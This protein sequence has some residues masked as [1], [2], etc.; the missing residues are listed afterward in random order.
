MS[1]PMVREA[2]P[3]TFQAELNREYKYSIRS[4]CLR[5]PHVKKVSASLLRLASHRESHQEM[6]LH[7]DVPSEEDR[8]VGI[9]LPRMPTTESDRAHWLREFLDC[10]DRVSG[11]VVCVPW[12]STIVVVNFGCEAALSLFRVRVGV[13]SIHF[14]YERTTNNTRCGVVT[15]IYQFTVDQVQLCS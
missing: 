12:S 11:C 6:H 4:F 7:P 1:S 10:P 2:R 14:E 13:S 15:Y 9:Q 8:G 5:R 3:K